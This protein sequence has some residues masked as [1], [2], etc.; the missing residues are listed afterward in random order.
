M[1]RLVLGFAGCLVV[2]SAA[3]QP[4]VAVFGGEHD[5]YERVGAHVR[6]APVWGNGW[7]GWQVGL[8][9]EFEL[10]RFRY[11]GE[12]RG[13]DDLN[14]AGAIA[15]FRMVRGEGRFRPYAE[16]GLGAALFSRT[17]LGSKEFSTAFQFSQHVGLGLEIGPMFTVGWRYSHYSNGDIE[18]PNNGID[19]H[20]LV[21]G[22]RL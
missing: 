9:P 4:E 6:L 7:G 5:N 11:V 13:A 10:S 16:A 20:Q 3:A 15:L 21:V 18:M 19:L 12:G 2:A 17:D 1:K 22:L 14:Q 8:H